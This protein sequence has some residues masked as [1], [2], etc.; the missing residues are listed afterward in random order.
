MLE[1]Q[2]LHTHTIATLHHLSPAVTLQNSKCAHHNVLWQSVELCTATKENSTYLLLHCQELRRNVENNQIGLVV[3]FVTYKCASEYI[4]TI[5]TS[6]FLV[7][8]V[9]KYF[10]VISCKQSL[11][12]FYLS[13]RVETLQTCVFP[14]TMHYKAVTVADFLLWLSNFEKFQFFFTNSIGYIINRWRLNHQW[15]E[16]FSIQAVFVK[17][18]S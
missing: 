18:F 6:L 9:S 13:G 12:H 2:E 17:D 8:L 5:L 7:S 4:C 3:I 14:V 15:C 10:W 1:L 11:T 16:Y